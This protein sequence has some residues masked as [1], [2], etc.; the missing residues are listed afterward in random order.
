M[1]SSYKLNTFNCIDFNGR[2]ELQLE[3]T[4]VEMNGFEVLDFVYG[5]LRAFTKGTSIT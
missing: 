4:L 3:I 5:V 2:V 1:Q